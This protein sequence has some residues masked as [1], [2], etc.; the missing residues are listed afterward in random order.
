LAA[1]RLP[2]SMLITAVNTWAS[3]FSGSFTIHSWRVL[4]EL[5][6]SF[7]SHLAFDKM[8]WASEI[9]GYYHN[10]FSSSLTALVKYL[11]TYS[12]L[13]IA[14]FYECSK[15][16]LANSIKKSAFNLV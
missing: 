3:T 8:I 14:L 5:W 13:P 6:I 7:E 16:S 12:P 4:R 10:T 1:A 9:T 2:E 11:G 15:Y